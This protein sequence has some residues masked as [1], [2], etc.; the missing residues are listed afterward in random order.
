MMWDAGWLWSQSRGIGLH[1]ELIWVRLSYFACLLWHQCPSWLVS[2]FLGTLWSS[3]KQITAPYVFYGEHG[4]PLHAVQGNRASSPGEG[5]VSWFF[6]SCCRNLEYI[7]ELRPEWPFKTRVCSV[8]SGV[9]SRYEG[10]L[11]NLHKA[12]QGNTDAAQG[13]AGDLVSLSSWHSDIGFPINF[14]QESGIIT[15]WSIEFHVPLKVSKGCEAS[16][17]DEEET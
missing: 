14:Q 3:I 7:L 17:P 16:C 1:L 13:E 10:H 6:S 9:L 4:I 11:R 15:F 12:W 2:V 5:D 8:T